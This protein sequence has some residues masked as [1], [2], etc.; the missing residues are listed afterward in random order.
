MGDLPGSEARARTSDRRHDS[1][2]AT[3]RRRAAEHALL[4]AVLLPGEP[5]GQ[6]I[7]ASAQALLTRA[8]ERL[9]R[10]PGVGGALAWARGPDARPR[11]LAAQ[12]ARLAHRLQPSEALYEA[13]TRTSE[14]VELTDVDLVSELRPLAARG[15]SALAPI[16]GLGETP[17]AMLLVFSS[18]PGRPLRPRTRAVLEE[19]A[20]SLAQSMSTHL[21]VDRL[22]QLDAA[23]QRLDRLAALGAMV[24]EIVH[25]V[26]NPLVSVKTFL[27]LLPER[28]GD[29]SF[30]REFRGLVEDEVARLERMLDDLLR[31]ARPRASA[32]PGEGARI[33]EAVGTTIQL[34]GY[35]C[36]ERA[37]DLETKIAGDL[38]RVALGDDALRQ[39]LLNLLLN[40]TSVTPSGGRVCIRAD[41]SQREP[42]SVELVV[43]DEGPGID[44]ALRAKLFEPFWTTRSE[45]AGGLGLAIC[46][47][48]VEEAGST[49]EVHNA[50]G[51]GACF[52]V[53]LD[54]AR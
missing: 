38:P 45:G 33:A 14:L 18:H 31:H 50:R 51:G 46:K 48:L 21:A 53:T 27:Q 6:G 10:Q 23:V 19:I 2:R 37:V 35:R 30:H 20:M 39:L 11:V 24:S 9:G 49:I 32:D 1:S 17:A 12:P 26:R 7:G 4:D 22:S 41:W 13:A 44:P 42:N 16:A 15:V 5:A 47:R 40:A 43:E 54:I 34:L 25:E 36:R 28:L 8:L 3:T 29:P 52:R